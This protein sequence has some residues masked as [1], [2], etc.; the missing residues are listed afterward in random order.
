MN[1]FM[2][3]SIEKQKM[4]IWKTLFSNTK[5]CQ[6]HEGSFNLGKTWSF[7]FASLFSKSVACNEAQKNKEFQE[8]TKK[9]QNHEGSC[10]LGK[11]FWN[12]KKLLIS[13]MEKKYQLCAL[14]E[15]GIGGLTPRCPS[16]SLHAERVSWMYQSGNKHENCENQI[17]NRGNN[18]VF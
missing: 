13:S 12:P 9:I 2:D 14:L 5:I 11:T 7:R 1:S 4:K 17:I 16:L 10:N 3:V 15:S 18:T 8:K 6:N